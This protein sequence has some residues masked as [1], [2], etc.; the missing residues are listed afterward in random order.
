LKPGVQM[1]PLPAWMA[2]PAV[3]KRDLAEVEIPIEPLWKESTVEM[4][5]VTVVFEDTGD[6]GFHTGLEAGREYFQFMPWTRRDRKSRGLNSRS[7]PAPA[8]ADEGRWR[9][10]GFVC[11]EV[12]LHPEFGREAGAATMRRQCLAT[13]ELPRW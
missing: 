10:G 8:D 6:G 4:Y 3:I 7:H 12:R 11:R 5:A 2:G 1:S 9:F 13:G